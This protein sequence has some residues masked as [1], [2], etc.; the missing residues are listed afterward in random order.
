MNT[1]E[2]PVT[3]AYQLKI[4]NNQLEFSRGATSEDTWL[5]LFG[6]TTG[7]TDGVV[8]QTNRSNFYF[9]SDDNTAATTN[10]VMRF[11]SAVDQANRDKEAP[12]RFTEGYDA[13]TNYPFVRLSAIGQTTAANN[14]IVLYPNDART[15]ALTNMSVLNQRMGYVANP[16][17]QDANSLLSRGE[18][19]A[20]YY[21]NTTRLDQI[22]QP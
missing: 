3:N 19:D 8:Q 12:L 15:S 17:L 5:K 21:L 22:V 14:N 10:M 1:G 4:D 7:S 13:I 20:R 9:E 2:D 11:S 16:T 6:T 18:N